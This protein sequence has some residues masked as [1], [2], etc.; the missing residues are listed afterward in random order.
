VSLPV[1]AVVLKDKAGKQ[2]VEDE[3]YDRVERVGM[4]MGR[5]FAPRVKRFKIVM[6]ARMIVVEYMLTSAGRD[7]DV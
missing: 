3:E 6:T 1:R 2:L 4:M 7:W 5:D